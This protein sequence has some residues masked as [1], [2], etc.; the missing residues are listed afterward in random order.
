ML[1][2]DSALSAL[3]Q[4]C[5]PGARATHTR[6]CLR[7]CICA[8]CA[9]WPPR[10]APRPGAKKS[11]TDFVLC[12]YIC[13][14]QHQTT[15]L[16]GYTD[17]AGITYDGTPSTSGITVTDSYNSTNSSS[18]T[19]DTKYG[20]G[21]GSYSVNPVLALPQHQRE[22][23]SVCVCV[24]KRERERERDT[25]FPTPTHTH[26]LQHQTTALSGYTDS[27]GTSYSGTPSTSG[28]T[29]TDSYNSTNSSSFNVD[30]KYGG[31]P[32]SYSVNPVITCKKIGT[33]EKNAHV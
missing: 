27:A 12:N 24:Y 23:E 15:A 25:V 1:F 29:V 2:P 19:I 11:P 33:I 10:G 5:A 7:F 3:S 18:F 31:G 6:F 26:T 9:P 28:F 8:R 16:S 13:Q 4:V 32:G 17:S 30:T 22:R 14:L 21:P 20:G